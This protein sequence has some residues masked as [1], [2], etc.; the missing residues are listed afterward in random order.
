MGRKVFVLGG[1]RSGKSSF[2]QSIIRESGFPG[3]YV[4]TA[5]ALD[6]EM[7][8]RIERHKKDRPQEWPT[9]EAPYLL[10]AK[11]AEVA[12][13]GHAVLVDCLAV[14][15]SNAVLAAVHDYHD[16]LHVAQVAQVESKIV[17]EV[18]SA[19]KNLAKADLAV[20]V[21]NEV[22]LSLVPDNVLGRAYR[23]IL[24]RVNQVTAQWADEVYFVI[25]GI[26]MM[27]KHK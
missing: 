13:Q 21:S 27:L 4:A 14:Y 25:S 20:V 2:A 10:P 6:E 23:D 9:I 16:T 19:L 26:P 5:E 7:K 3:Y 22:G 18:R 8:R 1:A 17:A 15:T 24:G 12:T 11:V